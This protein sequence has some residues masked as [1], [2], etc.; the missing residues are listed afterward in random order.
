[1]AEQARQKLEAEPVPAQWH[2]DPLRRA[3]TPFSCAL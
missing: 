2:R 1:M 3:S